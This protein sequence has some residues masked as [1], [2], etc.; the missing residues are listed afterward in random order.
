[1]SRSSLSPGSGSGSSSSSAPDYSA[2]SIPTKPA[3]EFTYVERRAELLQQVRDLGHPLRLNQSEAAERYGVSQQQINKDLDRIA[4][5]VSEDLSRRRH[6][7]T[8]SVVQRSLRGM[9]A[10][11]EWHRAAKMAL[12]WHEF[13]DEQTTLQELDERL[14]RMEAESG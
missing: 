8:E 2:V 12:K 7:T 1:M 9:L 3:H 10:D 13:V 5:H 11:E 6:L 4:D 14:S